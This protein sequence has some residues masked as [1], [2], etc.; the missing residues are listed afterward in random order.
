MLTRRV[1]AGG[2][3]SLKSAQCVPSATV[4][5]FAASPS[6]QKS[7]RAAAL[8]D[9]TLDSAKSFHE[10][11]KEFRDGLVAAQQRKEQEESA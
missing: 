9:I 11:Q 2:L 3:R 8:G 7:F 5:S 4:R 6:A 1:C 10:K